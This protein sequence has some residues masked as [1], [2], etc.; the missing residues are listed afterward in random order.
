MINQY[1]RQYGKR[2]YGFCLYLC[3]D[4]FEA[5]DLYQETWLK[6]V[7]HFSKYDSEKEFEPW[8]TKICV[9]TYR[10]TLRRITRSPLLDFSTNE[11]KDSALQSVPAPERKDYA[12]LYEAIDKLPEKLRLTVIL[13]YFRDMDVKGVAEVL[14]VPEGTIKSRLSKARKL[15]KEVL[16]DETDLQF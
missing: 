5:D 1:I 13:F 16:T 15:L 11:E 9:N 4:S 12:P 10:N 6:A 8:I 14:H 2:L 3:A 7:K